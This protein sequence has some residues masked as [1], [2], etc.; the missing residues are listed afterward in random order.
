M[1]YALL[2]FEINVRASTIIGAVGGGGIGEELKLSI[3]RGFGAKTLAI[4]LLLFITIFAVDQFSAWLRRKLVGEQAFD[5]CGALT[6]THAMTAAELER[7][8]RA[9]IPEVFHRPLLQALRCPLLIVA[10]HAALPR[11]CRWFFTLRHGDRA[12]GHWERCRHLSCA[13]WISYDLRPDD[14][15]LGRRREDHAEISALLAAGR[16]SRSRTG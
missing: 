16:Q 12:D 5:S 8:R 11:L 13:Q 15:R 2:R 1:S 14:P 3:S 7:D 6:M 4:V 10:R 9:A